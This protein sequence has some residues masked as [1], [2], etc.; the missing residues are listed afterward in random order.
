MEYSNTVDHYN[1]E[2]I[3]TVEKLLGI[4]ERFYGETTAYQKQ[5]PTELQV[6]LFISASVTDE[7]MDRYYRHMKQVD[8]FFTDTERVIS[9][10][11]QLMLRADAGVCDDLVQ[12][13]DS[14][15]QQYTV[16]SRAV[17]HYTSK[18]Q[19]ALLRKAPSPSLTDLFFCLRDFHSQIGR[20]LDF[21][22]TR[23]TE[24]K[25]SV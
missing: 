23:L 24:R 20:W 19:S 5:F 12:Q 18:S 15:I 22:R 2:L 21:L 1:S 8:L 14:I 16:L 6:G 4:S 17:H 25:K 11:S 13:C 9:L 7:W 10:L 3:E